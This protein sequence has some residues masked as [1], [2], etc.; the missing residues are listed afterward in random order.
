MPGL[1]PASL[2]YFADI[3]GLAAEEYRLRIKSLT[4]EEALLH[5]LHYNYSVAQL[6]V[7]KFRAVRRSIDCLWVA[8]V[9]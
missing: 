8:I 7:T 6:S 4:H 3:A 9:S 1:P 2:A 5:I